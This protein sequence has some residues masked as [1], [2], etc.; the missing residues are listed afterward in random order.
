[1]T[2]ENERLETLPE[3]VGNASG[4]D[5]ADSRV[6]RRT[7]VAGAAAAGAVGGLGVAA[8]GSAQDAGVFMPA[9]PVAL[10]ETIPQELV[11]FAGDWPS[12]AGNLAA[13]RASTNSTIDST[14]VDT[15][16]PAW[17][18]PLTGKSGYGAI[19]STSLVVG[20]TVLVQD[21][22]CNFIAVN[23]ETGEI[24]WQTDFNVGTHGPNGLA[25]GYGQVYGAL[26]NTGEI[27]AVS[28]ETGEL[29]WR[30][31][32]TN[33]P[34][35]SITIAPTIFD[36]TVY[37][38]TVPG[39]PGGPSGWYTGGTKGII[40]ALDASSGG[41]MWQW[42][43]TTDNLWGDNR[44][45]SGGGAWYPISVDDAGQ[46]YFGVGNPGP[47]PGTA[48]NPN[49]ESRPGNNLYTNSL[50]AFD[51][52]EG[53]V[54]WFQQPRPRDL[55]DLDFQNTPVVTTITSHGEEIPVV[56]GSGKNGHVIAVHRETGNLVW[57]ALVGKHQN[58]TL[59]QL[60]EEE[61]IEVFPGFNGAVQAPI[62]VANGR[63]YVPINNWPTW[64]NATGLDFSRIDESQSSGEF[65][66]LDANTGELLWQHITPS[67][68]LG[69]AAVANDVVATAGTDGIVR[70]YSTEDGTELW[71]FQLMAGVNAPV[72]IAG[73][74][75]LVGAGGPF[76]VKP[77]Q[78]P[79]GNVPE[80]VAELVAFKLGVGGGTVPDSGAASTPEPV[81]DATDATTQEAVTPVAGDDGVLA[82]TVEAYDLGYRTRVIT[83][84][85][86]TDV[87]ITLLNTGAIPHDLVIDEPAVNSGMLENGDSSTFVVNFPAGSY[88]YYCSV[89]GHRQAGMAGTITAE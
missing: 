28:F 34:G 84:P 56:I 21:M 12:P 71:N 5:A 20:D 17:R 79:D 27:A 74:M 49:S 48:G 15:L 77:G 43:T 13:T 30:V 66:A 8:L 24:K 4:S 46:L 67:L 75:L 69:A 22:Q 63:V 64:Y 1:M 45:N 14:N 76:M 85:A 54:R 10:G 70:A 72:S 88:D 44:A 65:L 73:D 51:S 52:A 68:P 38:S 58:D 87:A 47:F 3:G 78:F 59:E 35:E 40:Y 29:I 57:N 61:Y 2:V 89:S 32:L 86:D 18:L 53:Q 81:S 31:K 25:V 11:D 26:S 36:N 7:F 33:H 42:D 39:N 62:A 41:T 82:L 55:F 60:P 19:T 6:N 9:T 83:I 16:G 80:P 23:R 37:V 50:V